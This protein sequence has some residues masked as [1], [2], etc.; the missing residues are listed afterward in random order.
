MMRHG[1]DD[2]AESSQKL[3]TEHVTG[4]CDILRTQGVDSAED[5]AEEHSA[6]LFVILYFVESLFHDRQ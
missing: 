5:E 6:P 4:S 2:V 1:D 3:R